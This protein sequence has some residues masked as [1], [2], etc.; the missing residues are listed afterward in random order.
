MSAEKWASIADSSQEMGS[1]TIPPPTHLATDSIVPD[2]YK[3]D[4]A[5][6]VY[7]RG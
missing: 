2:T 1:A 5:R 3:E 7:G 6:E 4:P